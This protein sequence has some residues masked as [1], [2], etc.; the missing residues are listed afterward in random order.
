MQAIWNKIKALISNKERMRELIL[1]LVFGVLTTAVN[2]IVYFLV[3]RLLG[4]GGMEEGSGQYALTA[5]TGNVTAWVLA[6]LFA[7]FTNKKFVFQSGASRENGAWREFWLFVSARIA[8]LLIFDLMLFNLL[9]WLGM[10]A[11]WDKLIMN[12][13]VVIFNY[14]ASKWV[15]FRRRDAETA[16][17]DNSCPGAGQNGKDRV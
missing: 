6:V 14:A 13:L 11:D 12:V 8:S 5:N 17:R 15:I 7:F 1:Y 3:T 4:I 2:W 9:L 16:G 10:N